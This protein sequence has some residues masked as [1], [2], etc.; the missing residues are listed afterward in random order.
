MEF[1]QFT[2][3]ANLE[4]KQ[5]TEISMVSKKRKRKIIVN[6]RTFYWCVKHD[7]EDDDRLYLVIIS[8][9]K[10]MLVS[11]MLGQKYQERAFSPENPFIIVKGKEFKGLDGLGHA[12]ERFLVPEWDDEPV[13]PFLVSE[14][15]DWCLK[16]GKTIPVN[17]NGQIMTQR[18]R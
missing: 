12:W 16:P 7:D 18:Y 14:I 11:Y 6:N 2:Q 10:K 5:S 8:E 1:P 17:Y 15:I 13:T 9:D 4:A 3:T